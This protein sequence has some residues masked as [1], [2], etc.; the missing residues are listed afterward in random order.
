VGVERVELSGG[1]GLQFISVMATYRGLYP[2]ATCAE[3]GCLAHERNAF[4]VESPNLWIGRHDGCIRVAALLRGAGTG[5]SFLAEQSTGAPRCYWCAALA[6][7]FAIQEPKIQALQGGRL[8]L[9]AARCLPHWCWLLLG[10]GVLCGEVMAVAKPAAAG[11]T[12]H[13]ALI[14]GTAAATRPAG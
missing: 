7:V 11:G 14:I 6:F 13:G 4:N 3:T 5:G 2:W 9:Q 10:R 8:V 12:D 1:S